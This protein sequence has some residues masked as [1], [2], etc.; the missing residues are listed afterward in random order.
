MD[1]KDEILDKLSKLT[2]DQLDRMRD[3]KQ[4]E[5]RDIVKQYYKAKEEELIYKHKKRKELLEDNSLSKTAMLLQADDELYKLKRII[6]G[7]TDI[8]KQLEIELEL[9]KDFY[10]KARN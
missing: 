6:L 7:L 8:K 10:W 3:S 2:V 5:M 4:V 9:I 1:K